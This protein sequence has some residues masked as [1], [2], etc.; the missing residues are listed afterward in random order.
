MRSKNTAYYDMIEKYINDYYDANACP[1]EGREIAEA[2]GMSRPTV[3]RYLADMAQSGVISYDKYRRPVTVKAEGMSSSGAF[4]PVVGQ[5]ACGSPDFAEQD[6]EDYVRL[7]ESLTGKGEFFFLRAKGFSMIEAGI[8]PGDLVLIRK[9]NYADAGKIAAVLVDG[10]EA[11]L[12]RFYPER[13][14]GR[15]RLHPENSEMEDMYYT[16]CLVMGVAVLVIKK[17]E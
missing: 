16:D 6:I 12:K 10:S 4:V 8:D 3:T 5:I 2:L 7:P 1:P 15:V 13:E 9:Q 14:N 17:L 11:T